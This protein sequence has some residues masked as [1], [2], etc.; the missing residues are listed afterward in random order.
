MEPMLRFREVAA[1]QPFHAAMIT[2][3][4]GRQFAG[5]RHTHDFYELL[6]VLEGEG[7]HFVNADE[8]AMQVG[9]LALI[10]PQDAHQ[11]MAGG[12]VLTFINIAFP[13]RTWRAFADV[14]GLDRIDQWDHDATP[15]HLVVPATE[16]ERLADQFQ[17]ALHEYVRRPR[18]LDL[19]RLLATAVA[20]LDDASEPS[21]PPQPVWFAD[22]CYAMSFEE[23]LR[24]GVRRFRELAAVSAGHL[25]RITMKYLACRPGEYVNGRRLTHAATLLATTTESVTQIAHRCGFS[26]PS[27]FSQRFRERY[28]MSPR[29]YRRNAQYAVLGSSRR[30]AVEPG[31]SYRVQ[32]D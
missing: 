18:S 27:H 26:S 5:G 22:A 6:Y 3:R 32:S 11:F 20:V 7:R 8:L 9:V 2:L 4:P 1:G 24:Q 29:E 30:L 15:P 28:G 14:A 25:A 23:N 31:V 13:A 16:R 19:V 17:R 12:V 10:R 21:T